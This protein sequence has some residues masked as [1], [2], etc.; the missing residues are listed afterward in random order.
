MMDGL[1]EG[2]QRPGREFHDTTFGYAG[3]AGENDSGEELP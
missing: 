3:D 2:R 1:E